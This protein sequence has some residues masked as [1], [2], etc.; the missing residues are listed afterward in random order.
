[1]TEITTIFFLKGHVEF[2]NYHGI[3]MYQMCTRT[4]EH[5]FFR[6]NENECKGWDNRASYIF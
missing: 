5:V 4:S 2:M 6:M 3:I 1:M